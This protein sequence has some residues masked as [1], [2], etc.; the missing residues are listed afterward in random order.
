MWCAT[1]IDVT[2][3]IR[4]FMRAN[5]RAIIA[6][7]VEGGAPGREERGGTLSGVRSSLLG[8]HPDPALSCPGLQGYLAHQRKRPPRTLE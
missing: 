7:R 6:I 2:C 8:A 3:V 4:F 5:I 1:C